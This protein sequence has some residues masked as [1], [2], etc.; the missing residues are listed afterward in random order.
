MTRRGNASGLRS[1][2]EEVVLHGL[3]PDGA[4]RFVLPTLRMMSRSRFVDRAVRTQ[5]VLDGVHIGADVGR[6][7][8]YY[9]AA[10]AAP[11]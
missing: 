9:R 2:G 8:M 7:T 1:G 3:H 5:P 11:A 4:V 10:V 6:L